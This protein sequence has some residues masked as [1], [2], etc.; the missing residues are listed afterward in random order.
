MSGEKHSP[1]GRGS[2]LSPANRFEK[3][4]VEED[5]EHF[6]GDEEFLD[7]VSRTTTQYF[8]DSSKSIISEN[9]SPDVFFRYGLNP[10][11]GCSHGCAYCYARPTHEYLGLNA[12]IDFESKI[13]VKER[14]PELFREFLSRPNYQSELIVMSG[15][16]DCYQPAERKYRLTRGCLEVALEF[17]QPMEIITKNALIVRDL[18]LLALMAS[19]KLIEV[20][21]SLTSLDQELT[22]SLEPRTSS[23]TAKLRAIRALTDAGVPVRVMVSPII[24]GLN[25]SSIPAVLEAAR[26]AGAQAATYVLLRLPLTVAP[27]FQEWLERTHPTQRE[28]I[29]HLI[30]NTRDGGLYSSKFGE[31]MRGTG[32]IADQIQQTFRV[33]R[34][35]F[36]Y[37]EQLPALDYSNFE[38]PRPKSGQLRLF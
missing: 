19:Q 27:V 23:P 15:V 13:F 26:E 38:V 12:G 32:A 25:D 1:K 34:R 8:P 3:V 14:A 11:R 22:R 21:I 36:G 24:P 29:E 20:N 17:R 10:Y 7:E 33:F 18:D 5:W 31:R 16:T 30:Q 2:H 6:D 4:H 35:K 28:R 9:D 37:A